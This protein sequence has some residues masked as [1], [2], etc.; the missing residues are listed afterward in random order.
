[1]PGEFGSTDRIDL[2]NIAELSIPNE[3]MS[4]CLALSGWICYYEIK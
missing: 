2:K 3:Q 1:M 4:F